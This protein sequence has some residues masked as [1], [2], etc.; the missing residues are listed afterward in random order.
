[1]LFFLTL[2]FPA[3]W[4]GRVIGLFMTGVAISGLIGSPLS[5]LLLSLDGLAGL[6]GW[7]WLFI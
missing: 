6:R 2:W 7:Q 4:R 5:G 3:A 1:M